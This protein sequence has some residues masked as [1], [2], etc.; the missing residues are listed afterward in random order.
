MISTISHILTMSHIFP[1][2][3]PPEAPC[4]V[5]CVVPVLIGCRLVQSDPMPDPRL[6]VDTT[7]WTSTPSVQAWLTARNMT[8]DQ[9]Q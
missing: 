9:V 6:Q 2:T 5:P 7:C 8:A 4:A 1:I 3:V